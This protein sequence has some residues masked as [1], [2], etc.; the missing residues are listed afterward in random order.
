MNPSITDPV[1]HSKCAD[2]VLA[3]LWMTGN[4]S[5]WP[6]EDDSLPCEN[7]LDPDTLG[8]MHALGLIEKPPFVDYRPVRLTPMGRERAIAAFKTLC[9]A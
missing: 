6:V 4:L 3:A 9:A 1:D 7:C 8:Q 5:G 2:V